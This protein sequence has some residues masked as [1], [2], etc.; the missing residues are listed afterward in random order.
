[1]KLDSKCMIE[2]ETHFSRD[3]FSSLLQV[4]VFSSLRWNPSV[5]AA[6]QRYSTGGWRLTLSH[7]ES[8]RRN[9]VCS[10]KVIQLHPSSR[11]FFI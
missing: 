8:K 7:A 4:S 9:L 11:C 1:M 5:A 10:R 6:L 3:F 2:F